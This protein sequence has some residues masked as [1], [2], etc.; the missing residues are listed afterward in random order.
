MLGRSSARRSELENHE[1]GLSGHRAPNAGLGSRCRTR[2]R[3][4]RRHSAPGTVRSLIGSPRHSRLPETPCLS[5]LA[6]PAR[7]APVPQSP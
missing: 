5:S 2:V 1:A 6:D 4:R 3:R 7:R